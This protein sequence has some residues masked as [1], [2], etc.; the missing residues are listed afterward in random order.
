[1]FKFVKDCR[2]VPLAAVNVDLKK[3]D[4]DYNP[5]QT[6]DEHIIWMRFA[7]P[8]GSVFGVARLEHTLQRLGHDTAPRYNA[9]GS[10]YCIWQV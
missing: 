4:L 9:K 7:K 2:E 5:D 8:Y 6:E 10:V 3:L 1:M